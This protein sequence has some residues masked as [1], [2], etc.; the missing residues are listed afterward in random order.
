MSRMLHVS[1]DD[2]LLDTV[3]LGRLV[4]DSGF[5]PRHAISVWRGGTPVGLGIDAFFRSRGVF[6]HHSTITTASYRGI[7]DQGEVLVKNLEPLAQV[8][9]PE[10]DLLIIDDVYE[11]GRTIERIVALLR[12]LA[13]ANTPREIRVATVHRKPGLAQYRELPVLALHEVDD[14]AWLD[15]PHELVDLVSD[16]DPEDRRIANKSAAIWE[17]LRQPPAAPERL[18]PCEQGYRYV[19]PRELLLDAI[20]LGVKVAHDPSWRPTF[21]LA[22][23][24]GGALAGLPVHEVYKYQLRK[25]GSTEPTPDHISIDTWPARSSVDAV[26]ADLGYLEQRVNRRDNLLIVDTTFR[27]GRLVNALVLRLKEVLRR[28]LDDERI[29]VACIYYHPDD[30][31]TWTVRPQITA[32]H[33]FIKEVSQE[34]VTAASLHKLPDARRDLQRLNP[35]LAEVLYGA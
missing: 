25:S 15:Y 34:V 21:I 4:Y 19:N 23:W 32:P 29:R 9:C 6:M 8:V 35:A 22:L 28:N 11:S 17:A 20:R 14:G 18:A 16:A 7:G 33:Y 24:P 13:R 26:I 30:R 31:S 3:R 2:F 1:P 12:Q 5:R 27:A 10:D